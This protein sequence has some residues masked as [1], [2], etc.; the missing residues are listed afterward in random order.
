MIANK[1]KT[2]SPN[3]EPA[4][5]PSNVDIAIKAYEIWLKSG[6]EEGNDQQHWFEAKRQLQSVQLSR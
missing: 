1:E 3:Q 6:K 2:N 4:I 5:P